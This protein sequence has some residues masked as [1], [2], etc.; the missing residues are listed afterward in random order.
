MLEYFYANDYVYKIGCK[1][2]KFEAFYMDGNK[3]NGEQAKK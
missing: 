2:K 1:V 3:Q